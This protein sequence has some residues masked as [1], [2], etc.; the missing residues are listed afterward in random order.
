MLLAV[1]FSFTIANAQSST[2]KKSCGHSHATSASAEKS[3]CKPDCE[4]SCCTKDAKKS[5]TAEEKKACSKTAA[6]TKS[7]SGSKTSGKACCSKDAAKSAT[8]KKSCDKGSKKSCA[9]SCGGGAAAYNKLVSPT[10]FKAY[11]DRFP[12][13]QVVDVR[14][15]S[16][17]KKNGM[18]DGAK[19]I[20]FKAS[21]FK[22][23]MGKLDK[24]AAVMVYCKSG[25]RS[26]QTV[27]VLKEM[28]FKKIYD[29]DGGFDAYSKADLK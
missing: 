22:E 13:E 4:K 12:A 26:A 18:I 15:K 21:Y 19:N 5:C 17:I 7:C 27:L 11:M 14:T 24:N 8:A 28:G 10:D 29:M 1:T 9:K 20:D 2:V 3:E 23:E 6:S 16:E 25:K